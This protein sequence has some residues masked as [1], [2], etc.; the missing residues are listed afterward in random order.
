MP[1]DIKELVQGQEGAFLPWYT[2]NQ[3]FLFCNLVLVQFYW[4]VSAMRSRCGIFC[5]VTQLLLEGG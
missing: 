3:C 2:H 1:Q 4:T 5:M